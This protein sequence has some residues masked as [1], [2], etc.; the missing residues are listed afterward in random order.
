MASEK[1]EA[2]NYL[3]RIDKDHLMQI[4]SQYMTGGGFGDIKKMTKPKIIKILMSGKTSY[5]SR[6]GYVAPKKKYGIVDN[7]KKKK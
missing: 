1:T 2:L 4:A 5:Y 3:K 7:L 6:G